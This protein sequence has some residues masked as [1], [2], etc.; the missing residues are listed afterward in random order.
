MNNHWKIVLTAAL[1]IGLFFSVP[2]AE[3]TE[4][5]EEIQAEFDRLIEIG[6]GDILDQFLS[7]L[8]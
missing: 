1:C 3:A 2:R 4:I 5:P 7:S 8:P 6:A